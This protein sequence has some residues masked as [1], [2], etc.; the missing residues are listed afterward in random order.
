MITGKTGLRID[1]KDILI[2]LSTIM[3]KKRLQHFSRFTN[4]FTLP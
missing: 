3:K 4:Q 2:D 1:K